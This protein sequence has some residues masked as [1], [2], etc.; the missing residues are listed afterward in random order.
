M[1][2]TTRETGRSGG[3]FA[4]YARATL[5]SFAVFLVTLI[6][7]DFFIQSAE[8][9]SPMENH[10]VDRIGLMYRPNFRFSRF[11]EGFFLGRTNEYGCLGKGAPRAKDP[12]TIRIL[13]LGDSFA[14]GHTVF[15]RHHFAERIEEVVSAATGQPTEVLN[16]ARADFAVTNCYQHYVD[17]ASQWEHDL[18]LFLVDQTDLDPVRQ[19]SGAF[20]PFGV[21][22]A[23]TLRFDYG[24]TD[25]P[26]ARAYARNE[27]FLAYTVLPRFVF[28]VLK[29]VDRGDLPH[30]LFDKLVPGKPV[31]AAPP[32]AV[33]EA[34]PM[35][36][37]TRLVLE[38]IAREPRVVVVL[39][40]PTDRA[41]VEE[42]RSLD[43]PVFD[44][45]PTFA[46]LEAEGI[47][48][49]W[50]EVTGERGHWNHAA[51]RAIG[52]TLGAGVVEMLGR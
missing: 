17:F 23:D 20:Y 45:D 25:T 52:E 30:L 44:L 32:I 29:V 50:W 13:F 40:G 38:K 46:R 49:Y 48:P 2:D 47:D 21:V 16:F 19:A 14:L 8:I 7:L 18:A 5:V 33:T 3:R 42:I 11:S 4:R 43:I 26:K 12:G 24:F 31:L 1:K 37:I 6:A 27:P 41:Y 39:S 9:Q 35:P 15:E 36:Q 10:L 28:E 22:E 34:N 51:H